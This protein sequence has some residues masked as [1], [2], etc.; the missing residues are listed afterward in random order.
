MILCFYSFDEWIKSYFGFLKFCL[1][2][3]SLFVLFFFIHY[4][5]L[6]LLC[7]F[8]FTTDFLNQLIGSVFTYPNCNSIIITIK[9]I[10]IDQHQ[11]HHFLLMSLLLLLT[12]SFGLELWPKLWLSVFLDVLF[13]SLECKNENMADLL[14]NYGM[15]SNL[16][17]KLV[18]HLILVITNLS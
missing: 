11:C 6:F 4:C 3:R 13:L 14:Y 17:V 5:I 15:S 1:Q 8:L 2:F 7:T 9:A 16:G 12:T 18:L 10:N